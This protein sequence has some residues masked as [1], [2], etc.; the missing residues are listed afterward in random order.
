MQAR[1]SGKV[2]DWVAA[3][4]DA[5]LRPPEGWCHPHRFGSFSPPRGLIEDGS[6]AQ[7]FVDGQA[8]FDAIALS[9]EEAKSE[10]QHMSL[11]VLLFCPRFFYF[12]LKDRKLWQIYI[13]GWWLCPELYL[14]RPFHVNGAS[15]L[16]NLL[17]FKAKQGVQ[18]ML[19]TFHGI[20]IH[21]TWVEMLIG[22]FKEVPI[23]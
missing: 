13:T 6:Q 5:G 8:A 18:V 14:R 23:M 15:R 2:K 12:L 21:N 22:F 3:I 4:N 16:D 11:S 9:I 19:L 17:E 10:V 7:W 1:S 20:F